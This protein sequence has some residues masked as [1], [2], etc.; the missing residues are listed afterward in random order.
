[1]AA[2][3]TLADLV[4]VF[5]TWQLRR[6]EVAEGF[7]LRGFREFVELMNYETRRAISMAHKEDPDF[8][9]AVAEI[10]NNAALLTTKGAKLRADH[11]DM[12]NL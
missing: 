10:A 1:M 6:K 5:E 12:T 4:S 9:T 3:P 8:W 2:E 11:S 7:H